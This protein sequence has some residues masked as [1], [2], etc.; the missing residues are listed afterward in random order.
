MSAYGP[1]RPFQIAGLSRYD[2]VSRAW[3]EYAA[4]GAAPRP[5]HVLL[6][7]Q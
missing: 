7:K 1:E 6:S 2:A 3:R 5:G 4:A